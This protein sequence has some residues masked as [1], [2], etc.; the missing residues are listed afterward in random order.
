MGVK[1]D[2]NVPTTLYPD[3]I[4]EFREE[5]WQ[6]IDNFYELEWQIAQTY[7]IGLQFTY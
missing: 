2:F 5:L 6:N 7:F 3:K 1:F 4:P